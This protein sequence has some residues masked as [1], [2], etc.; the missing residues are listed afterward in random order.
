[1]PSLEEHCCISLERT[2]GKDDF[3]KLH[4]WMDEPKKD[5]G[6]NHRMLR[7]TDNASDRE[8]VKTHWGE[9]AVVEWLFHIAI[10]N[11]VTAYKSSNNVYGTAYNY[12]RIAIVEDGKI[13]LTH[14]K[15]SESQLIKL[16]RDKKD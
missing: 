11:L 9:K 16:F 7:H 6:V 5:L 4:E 3:R 2:K 8:F 13:I 1:M 10:D 12:Y 14:E 15:L